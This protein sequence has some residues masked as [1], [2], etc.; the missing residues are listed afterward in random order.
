MNRKSKAQQVEELREIF[1]G[2]Q[3]TV[4]ARYDG[5]AVRHMVDLRSR[6]REV[7]GGFRVV[8][9]TL[10][11]RAVEDTDAKPL[12]SQMVGPTAVAWS[13]A[14]AVQVA[15]VLQKFA[16]ENP[17]L[18]IRAGL[19]SGGEVL[20]AEDV[21]R[22]SKMP[23]KQELRGML[24]GALADVPRRLLGV[25]QASARD[26]AGVLEARRRDLEERQ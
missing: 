16:K 19:L 23:G 20:G 7:D 17:Q 10:A 18:E 6:L 25:L 3:L 21:E 24:L 11:R 15:K 8:K 26:M 22:L 5:L 13:K 2:N 4:L 14:D 9:N 12:E 1:D